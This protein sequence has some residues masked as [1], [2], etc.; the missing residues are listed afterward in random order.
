MA[1]IELFRHTEKWLGFEPGKTIF[2]EG[3]PGDCM[4]VILEGE[5]EIH[6]GGKLIE[7]AE[8]GSTLGELALIDH[9]TRSATAVARSATRLVPINAKQFQGMIQETPFFALQVMSIMAERLRRWRP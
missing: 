3:D 6:A 9:S 4:Y 7:L 8:A 5:V 2:A 1:R